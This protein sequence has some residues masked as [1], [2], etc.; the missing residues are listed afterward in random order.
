MAILPV[1]FLIEVDRPPVDF[2]I[3]SLFIPVGA[4]VTV[5]PDLEQ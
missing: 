4:A 1:I 3:Q 5:Q 2:F